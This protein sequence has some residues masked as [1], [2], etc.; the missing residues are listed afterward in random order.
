MSGPQILQQ[1]LTS[2]D[3]YKAIMRQQAPAQEVAPAP[4]EPDRCSPQCMTARVCLRRHF[5]ACIQHLVGAAA[6]AGLVVTVADSA[7][8]VRPK[9][10]A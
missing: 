6:Q 2:V 9:G 3:V 8:S 10:V 5:Q 4:C 1:P 7:V